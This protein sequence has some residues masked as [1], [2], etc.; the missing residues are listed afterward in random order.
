MSYHTA[1]LPSSIRNQV[2]DYIK[3]LLKKYGKKSTSSGNPRLLIKGIYAGKV[4]MKDDFDKPL[5]EFRD[6]MP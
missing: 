6:Y 2:E 4:K 5:D 1:D 3:Y